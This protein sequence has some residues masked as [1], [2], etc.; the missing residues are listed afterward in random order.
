LRELADGPARKR[1]G[2]LPQGRAP[3]RQGS[4]ILDGDGEVIGIVTSGGFGPSAGRPV[5]MGYVKAEFAEV[6]TKIGLMV[7]GKIL[8][9]E[10]AAMPFVEQRYYRKPKSS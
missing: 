9:G 8:P 4:D 2:I 10:V 6:G 1:V 3:V 5:A 7:R